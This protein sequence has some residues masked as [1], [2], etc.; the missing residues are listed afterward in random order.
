MVVNTGSGLQFHERK[1][2]NLRLHVDTVR[3]FQI[4]QEVIDEGVLLQ[5]I[6]EP[7]VLGDFST[8]TTNRIYDA[9]DIYSI[10]QSFA[11]R[12]SKEIP[13]AW[14]EEQLSGTCSFR[15][16]L[17]MTMISVGKD[18]Y[19]VISPLA[20]REVTEIGFEQNIGL[21]K[22]EPALAK[23][24]SETI[25]RLFVHISK[26][27]NRKYETIGIEFLNK[28]RRRLDKLERL[29]QSLQA[30]LPP[31]KSE[32]SI[33]QY[34]PDIPT[35]TED[36]KKSIENSIIPAPSSI[37]SGE[38]S[39][40]TDLPLI[41]P[42]TIKNGRQLIAAVTNFNN[43][44]QSLP[45]IDGET[46]I[47]ISQFLI[48]LF[49][50]LI[51]KNGQPKAA[52]NSDLKN[53]PKICLS[54][55]QQLKEIADIQFNIKGTQFDDGT[56]RLSYCSALAVGWMLG[57]IIDDHEDY[58]LEGK[59]SHYSLPTS[60][61]SPFINN[62]LPLLL[63]P[64]AIGVFM[65]LHKYFSGNTDDRKAEIFTFNHDFYS[66]HTGDRHWNLKKE[67]TEYAY[68]KAHVHE[69]SEGKKEQASLRYATEMEKYHNFKT[70]FEPNEW[71][72]NFC[73]AS[74]LLPQ[75]FLAL[76]KLALLAKLESPFK[77][78]WN[79][80]SDHINFNNG[81]FLTPPDDSEY[82]SITH[83]VGPAEYLKS[84]ALKLSDKYLPMKKGKASY[85]QKSRSIINYA[86]LTPL[87]QNAII[88]KSDLHFHGLLS[89]LSPNQK[90]TNLNLAIAMTMLL[91]Y[92]E[93]NMNELT[94]QD[95]RV[96]FALMTGNSKRL[97]AF[98]LKPELAE[99]F[100][101]FFE[102]SIDHFKTQ[103]QGDI[104][105]EGSIQ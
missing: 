72:A 48:T 59:L 50:A 84:E 57:Q 85:K 67:S 62:D 49:Q 33:L 104:Q 52:L 26:N 46:E 89:L 14:M 60:L 11:V 55:I 61:L 79:K 12:P 100:I 35:A 4:P 6:F 73:Y 34:N 8:K 103:V 78:A 74:N 54:T 66:K 92:F 65:R 20:K 3:A 93:M 22:S 9:N 64:E 38:K 68:A 18:A 43:Y 47:V 81:V 71:L 82:L 51:D 21:I 105:K 15:C 80:T 17:A 56:K 101:T 97:N 77:P 96:V 28:Q 94:K 10:F 95:T 41:T 2:D 19:K 7:L 75:H 23:L 102:H 40:L 32:I 90:K 45:K 88:T 99:E 69:L 27:I 53:N 13:T 39:Q 29:L 76:R 83:I 36:I 31:Q 25:P 24:F 87:S 63:D 44:L 16:T 86:Y 37:S 42:K 30:S 5:Q 1:H 58:S 70:D 98:K 91:D